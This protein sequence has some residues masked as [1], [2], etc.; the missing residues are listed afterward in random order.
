MA[1]PESNPSTKLRRGRPLTWTW[2][3]T[4]CAV[5]ITGYIEE[6]NS[7]VLN[8]L[9]SKERCHATASC[10]RNNVLGP[11]D[12][13]SVLTTSLRC[14]RVLTGNI[15][16]CP[17]GRHE[18]PMVHRID[19]QVRVRKWKCR[20]VAQPSVSLRWHVSPPSEKSGAV[21]NGAT[22]ISPR[23]GKTD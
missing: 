18:Q 4:F 12:P 23:V 15:T 1:R 13:R 3:V 22:F 10:Y 20:S 16:H 9:R 11:S 19:F 14:N 8:R 21:V 2:Y 17:S 6:I 5:G 7:V